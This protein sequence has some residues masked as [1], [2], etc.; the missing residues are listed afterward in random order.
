MKAQ[1]VG[2]V[3]YGRYGRFL[4]SAWGD[5]VVA[6]CARHEPLRV[7]HP[8]HRCRDFDELLDI[9]DIDVVA[10]A[11]PPSSHAALGI[12]A[13]EAGMDVIVEKPIATTLEDAD[14]LIEARDT[15]GRVATVD[16]VL[17]FNPL[18]AAATELARA[19]T[20]GAFRSLVV[21]NHADRT[22]IPPNHW[23]WNEATSGGI[24]VEHGV[25][26]F[27]LAAEVAGSPG[28]ETCGMRLGDPPD[29]A[30]ALVRH[31]S[32]SVSTHLHV[33]DRTAK[34][35]FTTIDIGFDAGSLRLIGWMPLNAEL[36][37]DPT[38]QRRVRQSLE[39]ASGGLRVQ[40]GSPMRISLPH[41]KPDVYR[42]CVRALL[43]TVA[44]ERI[45][46]GSLPVT[47]EDGRRALATAQAATNRHLEEHE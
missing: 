35:E 38:T 45:D 7:E 32:G 28:V 11:T 15:T 36:W 3:G 29:G 4:H 19:N 22:Q 23:F 12:Q 2:I 26:F 37:T 34:T 14:A 10:I 44:T 20:M 33:F 41:S 1:T 25:H 16:H 6:I 5:A 42:S 8:V 9:P 46:P 47:L 30:M 13:M 31:E 40:E 27:D 18:V 43:S 24:L 39:Q 17:R 21:V